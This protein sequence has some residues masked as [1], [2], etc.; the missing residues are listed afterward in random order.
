MRKARAHTARA[1]CVALDSVRKTLRRSAIVVLVILSM[2]LVNCIH[3]QPF[4]KD[5]RD[6]FPASSFSLTVV[7][8]STTLTIGSTVPLT[9]EL[10]NTWSHAV[11][12]CADGWDNYHFTRPDGRNR[13]RIS[14]T[15]DGIALDDI[16]RFDLP[17]EN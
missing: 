17:P 3:R 12:A 10:T 4:C 2:V 5:D 14:A 6:E 8:S 13:G 15:S 7:P 9:Y 11:S 16:V 1:L